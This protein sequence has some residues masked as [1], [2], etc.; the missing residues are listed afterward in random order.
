MNKEFLLRKKVDA[1]TFI[2]FFICMLALLF[3]E[4]L[5]IWAAAMASAFVAVTI[6]LFIVGKI[7]DIFVSLIIFGL[8][9]VTNSY[10]ESDLWTGIL[11]VIGSGYAFIRQC[12]SIY[13]YKAQA[14]AKSEPIESEDIDYI[15]EEDDPKD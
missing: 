11:L 8:L 15:D 10:L 5:P 2:L 3:L 1:L 7:L 14:R 9:F 13:M 6:R 12:F 4:W